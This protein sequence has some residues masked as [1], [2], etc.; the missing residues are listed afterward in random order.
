MKPGPI[1]EYHIKRLLTNNPNRGK[2]GR[3]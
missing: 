1:H 2:S 3:R